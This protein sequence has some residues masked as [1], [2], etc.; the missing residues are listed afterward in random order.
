M[1]GRARTT[2]E[3]PEPDE[4]YAN[5]YGIQVARWGQAP[6]VPNGEWIDPVPSVYS[7]GHGGGEVDLPDMRLDLDVAEA[8]AVRILAAVHHERRALQRQADADL[9]ASAQGN[10]ATHD[11][12]TSHPG[13]PRCRRCPTRAGDGAIRKGA[14]PPCSPDERCRQP[15]HEITVKLGTGL[16][17]DS[18]PGECIFCNT[19]FA[20]AP[21]CAR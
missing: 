2:V 19:T 14:V 1:T 9:L 10:G 18:A 11:W 16:P 17:I 15:W 20:P 3:L 8:Y 4:T 5:S 6:G 12:D 7:T 21:E 13:M